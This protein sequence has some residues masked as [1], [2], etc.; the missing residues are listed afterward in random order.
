YDCIPSNVALFSALEQLETLLAALHFND[1]A[2]QK[3][4]T[5]ETLK[6]YPTFG[7]VLHEIK[8]LRCK[9]PCQEGGGK[10]T[11]LLSTVWSVGAMQGAGNV[12]TFRAASCLPR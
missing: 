5:N 2:R 12:L 10:L 9:A 8:K 1:Y 11:A 6:G 4:Q 7:D 3:A